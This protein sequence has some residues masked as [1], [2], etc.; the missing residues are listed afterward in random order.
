MRHHRKITR[1]LALLS[2][3]FGAL[4]PGRSVGE[5]GTSPTPGDGVAI[6]GEDSNEPEYAVAPETSPSMA[7]QL[8]PP[9]PCGDELESAEVDTPETRILT[10]ITYRIS[11]ALDRACQINAVEPKYEA[12]K[13]GPPEIQSTP[14]DD[15]TLR[16]TF[17]LACQYERPGVFFTTPLQVDVVDPLGK[18][19]G[20]YYPGNI[21]IDVESF[22]PSYRLGQQFKPKISIKPWKTTRIRE[23]LAITAA[24][25]ILLA[26]GGVFFRLRRPKP[27]N[28]RAEHVSMSPFEAFNARMAPLLDIDPRSIEETKALYDQLAFAMRELID[29]LFHCDAFNRTTPQIAA[30]LRK[31]RVADSACDELEQI[32]TEIDCVKFTVQATNHAATLILMR[33]LCKCGSTLDAIA[34]SEEYQNAQVEAQRCDQPNSDDA[35]TPDLPQ[36]MENSTQ[37]PQGDPSS[38]CSERSLQPNAEPCKRFDPHDP[39]RFA[40]PGLADISPRSPDKPFA[41]EAPFDDG[42]GWT[43]NPHRPVES[44]LFVPSAK[45]AIGDHTLH[46]DGGAA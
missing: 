24:V 11:V 39:M 21:R 3:G 6:V 22:D 33:E 10:T 31:K 25:V 45:A 35:P 19:V 30:E 18:R 27:A 28:V 40:P 29:A 4:L 9:N 2:I 8:S 12:I 16:H 32:L 44:E 1:L 37:S 17:T 7:P 38:D 23:I 46:D 13:C 26:A 34:H 15:D 43:P 42:T 20:R 14:V 5:E 41:A 36:R